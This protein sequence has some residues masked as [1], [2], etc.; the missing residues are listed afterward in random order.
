[1]EYF[2]LYAS[3][4]PVKGYVQTALCDLHRN[5][6]Y[7]F[8]NDLFCF[9]NE[10]KELSVDDMKA[11]HGMEYD[12]II[13]P[14]FSLLVGQNI[15]FYT[16][17]PELFPDMDNIWE[18]PNL[19][20][21]AIIDVD[22]P[23][24]ISDIVEQLDALGCEALQIRFLSNMSVSDMKRM[25]QAFGYSRLR[26][27]EAYMKYDEALSQD[28]YKE[29]LTYDGRLFDIVIYGSPHN[30]TIIEGAAKLV[31][32]T[33]PDI[34]ENGI[35][36]QI[37]KEYFR[38]NNRLF[39]ESHHYNSCLNRK[40]YIN[41]TGDIKNCPSMQESYGNIHCLSIRNVFN[42]PSFSKM[43]GITKN[44]IDVCK[45]CEFRYICTDCRCMIKDPNYHYSQPSKCKYNPYIGKWGD[46]EGYVPVEECGSYSREAG[47]VPD[48]EKI[49]VFNEKIGI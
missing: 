38:V 30:G 1:M 5:K 17:T 33:I 15:G 8:S 26:S 11:K 21:N 35:C 41:P 32:S 4:I 42:N 27:I 6:Y 28:D 14:L 43:W 40:L 45:D 20:T 31:F 12:E 9:I 39:F 46:E 34:C 10:A 49:R 3:C 25:I 44:N 29:M 36:G 48:Y 23:Y 7:L 37:G 13:D 24:D 2:K 47:F 16:D 22:V 19:I 18:H